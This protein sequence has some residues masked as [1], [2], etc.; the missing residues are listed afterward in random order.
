MWRW[1]ITFALIA[2]MFIPFALHP[3]WPSLGLPASENNL[4]LTLLHALSVMSAAFLLSLIVTRIRSRRDDPPT[5]HQRA[6]AIAV[7][8]VIV[9]VAALLALTHA[10]STADWKTILNNVKVKKHDA[11]ALSD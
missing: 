3:V 5:R 1:A 9:Y 7:P 6:N 4:R 8:I 2:A 11:S 10:I